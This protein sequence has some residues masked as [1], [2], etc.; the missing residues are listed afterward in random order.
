MHVEEESDELTDINV[1]MT[2]DVKCLK[3]VMTVI[4]DNRRLKMLYDPGAAYSVIGETTWDLLGRPPLKEAADLLAYTN[5]LVHTLGK[6]EVTVNAFGK[7][8]NVEVDVVRGSDSS[9][10][11][12]DWCMEFELPFPKGIRILNVTASDSGKGENNPKW[13]ALVDEFDDVFNRKRGAIIG[14]QAT[15]HVQE[16][17]IPRAFKARPVP[18]AIRKQVEDEIHRSWMK[19]YWNRSILLASK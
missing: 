6:A 16:N 15:V 13:K 14:Y 8:R 18:F 3:A 5:V 11:G 7:K 19:R 10:F 17:A 9:L 1:I 12:L 2:S 4:V